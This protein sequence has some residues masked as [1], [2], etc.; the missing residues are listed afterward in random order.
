MRRFLIFVLMLILCNFVLSLQR[1]L[2]A[3]IA[4]LG[5]T[6]VLEKVQAMEEHLQE[7]F[8]DPEICEFIP[9]LTYT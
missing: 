3:V 6:V 1:V 8:S 2:F 4:F 7:I 5:A 9:P